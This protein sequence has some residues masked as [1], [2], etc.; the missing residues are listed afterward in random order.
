MAYLCRRVSG[1]AI[2]VVMSFASQRKG[3]SVDPIVI[4]TAIVLLLFVVLRILRVGC[5]LV[6]YAFYFALLL[7]AAS[8]LYSMLR[9]A[10]VL[11]G[12]GLR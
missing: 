2:C 3:L 9:Q 7:F 5:K 1:R 8:V 4:V 12:T 6:V 11:T 10:G